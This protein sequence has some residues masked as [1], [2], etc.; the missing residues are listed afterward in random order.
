MYY[1]YADVFFC[2]GESA[3]WDQEVGAES[4]NLFTTLRNVL[5]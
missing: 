5:L 1:T 2:D 4:D 3:F